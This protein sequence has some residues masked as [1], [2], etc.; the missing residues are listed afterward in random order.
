M[1]SDERCR[2]A[3]R[4]STRRP[5]RAR[6]LGGELVAALAAARGEDGAAGPRGHAQPEAVGLGTTAVVRLEGALA[7]GKGSLSAVVLEVVLAGDGAGT[8]RGGRR[9]RARGPSDGGT[10]RAQTESKV[11]TPFRGV[12]HTIDDTPLEVL[13]ICAK[14][15][16]ASGGPC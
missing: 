11:R 14:S 7:H 12:K 10:W 15:L 6:G 16:P 4:G 13:D 5:V 8:A 1:K 2:R 9:S 3:D